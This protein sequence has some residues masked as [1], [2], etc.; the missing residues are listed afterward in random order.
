MVEHGSESRLDNVQEMA[1]LSDHNITPGDRWGLCSHPLPRL[2][3]IQEWRWKGDACA[4][5]RSIACLL[6]VLRLQRLEP[7]GSMQRDRPSSGWSIV[8]DPL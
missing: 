5:L 1:H 4:L 3:R 8:L 2:I 7:R 6:V